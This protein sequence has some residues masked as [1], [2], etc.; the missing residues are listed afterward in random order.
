MITIVRLR[1]MVFGFTAFAVF[2]LVVPHGY[3]D[4][5]PNGWEASNMKAIGYSD[6]DGR[7][8]AFKM[9]IRHVNDHWYLYMGH[10]W[11]RGWSIVDVTDPTNPKVAN[12]IPGPDNTW[13]IQ[14]ELQGNL[15][16][17]ALQKF[18]VPWGADPDKPND[19][20]VLIWDI[21]D[22]VNPKLLSH[23]KT[24]STGVHRLGYPGGKYVNLAA[25]MPG[26]R[27]QI[28]VFLDI[29]DPR[30]PK[31]AGKWWEKGQKE[32][33]PMPETPI[34]FHGPAY[35]DGNRAY[36]G[37]SNE[38]AILDISDISNPKEISHLTLS[39]PFGGLPVHDVKLIPGRD[40]VYA[41]GEGVRGDSLTGPTACEGPIYLDGLVNV[42]DPKKPYLESLLPRPVPPPGLPYTDFCAK[43]GRF[44]PH[45]TNLEYHLPDVEKQGN[46]IYDAYFNAGLR[47]FDIKDA[48]LPKESGWFIP[49]TPTKRMGPV[50]AKLVTQTEDVL[51]DTRGNIYITDKQ[52]G[53]WILRYSGPDEPAPTAK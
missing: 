8:G 47:I 1:H 39:P 34:S 24:G 35:I 15:M 28:L 19:E 32:G 31:V 12:F 14:M 41:H 44:G 53:L 25:N 9:A 29:S 5:I 20:G 30:N 18:S 27:G 46:L 45:N 50:P 40:L 48:D 21:S 23:W 13:T 51:V 52:W 49:P 11:N 17:T 26:Y 16:I 36:L 4:Q 7:G 3:A 33:E 37:Y 2:L 10:L 43:G 42:K 6:L 22:P 38:F